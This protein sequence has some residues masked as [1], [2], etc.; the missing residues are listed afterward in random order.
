MLN[1]VTVSPTPMEQ[2]QIPESNAQKFMRSPAGMVVGVVLALGLGILLLYLGI[3]NQCCG[4]GY[5]LVAVVALYIPKMFG[6]TKTQYLAVFGVV[7]FLVTAAV[8]A[9]A[10]SKPMFENSNDYASFD[11]KGFSNVKI[12][13]TDITVTYTGTE[14][15][16]EPA[17]YVYQIKN[18]TYQMISKTADDV[19][20]HALTETSPGS[21][22]YTTHVGE[23]PS[24]FV[25]QLKFEYKVGED[26]K[27]T[28]TVYYT[29]VA[30]DSDIQKFC[31]I[32][33]AYTC[34]IIILLFFLMMVLTAWSRKNLEKAR[35]RMEAE[36]R[37]YPQGYGRCKECGSI[38]LPGETCCRKCGAYIDVPDE[39][40]H[41]KVDMVECSE[42]GAEIPED[43]KV[44]PK[45]GATFDEEEEVVY[46]DAEEKKEE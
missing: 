22:T 3:F 17:V 40:R 10:V 44:C 26:T 27:T 38:V 34:G 30:S 28:S 12:D 6:M 9:F 33:N 32:Y 42:C 24:T 8:G 29:G 1:R 5:L 2:Q 25:Y 20:R 41:R 15:I 23:I 19:S 31:L 14:T 7:F 36:G 11:D 35:A 37:L 43:A 18:V 39:L 13:G 46:V 21:N 4:L 16:T 45:C